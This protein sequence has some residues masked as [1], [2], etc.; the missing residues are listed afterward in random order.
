M[1]I[2]LKSSSPRR[3]ELLTNMGYK[4]EIKT[5]DVDETFDKNFQCLLLFF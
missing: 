1:E 4:F 3:K 5:F 2:V